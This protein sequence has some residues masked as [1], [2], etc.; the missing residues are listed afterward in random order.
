M[1]DV[2]AAPAVTESDEAAP[3]FQQP[4]Y[5]QQIVVTFSAVVGVL[6]TLF[7]L[8]IFGTPVDRAAG[9]AYGA[10]AHLLS[11]AVPAFRVWWAVYLGLLAYLVWQWLPI[12][13][14]RPRE[15]S[16]GWWACGTLVLN[17]AWLMMTQ[18]GRLWGSVVVMA[19]L[20]ANL[21]V[22]YLLL[23]RRPT[24]S[25]VELV[26]VDGTF[27]LYWGWICVAAVANLT[28]ALKSSGLDP[29]SPTADYLAVTVL[30]AVAALGV[31]IARATRGRLIPAVGICWGVAWI[32]VGRFVGEPRSPLV[33]WACVAVIA[34]VLAASGWAFFRRTSSDA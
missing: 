16:L 22:L 20:V 2:D 15:P 34:V 24:P 12:A 5:L 1:S 3:R 17:G 19:L 29:A 33:G 9:G 23:L 28:A 21:T 13:R 6:G 10:S 31:F 14:R 11:P 27:G 30:V 25:K 32:A 26:V 18:D 4:P 8:G 7:G